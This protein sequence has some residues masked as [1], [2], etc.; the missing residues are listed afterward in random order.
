M[1]WCERGESEKADLVTWG[2]ESRRHV[3]Q[4]HVVHDDSSSRLNRRAPGGRKGN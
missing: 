4:Q 1:G 2:K 3:A